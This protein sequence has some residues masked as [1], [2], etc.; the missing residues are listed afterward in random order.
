MI[1]KQGANMSWFKT[2]ITETDTTIKCFNFFGHN[3][4]YYMKKYLASDN[5]TDAIFLK[6]SRISGIEFYKQFDLEVYELF[7]KLTT[8]KNSSYGL[9]K[10]ALKDVVDWFEKEYYP[11]RINHMDEFDFSVIDEKMHF[12]ILPH[13]EEA[14][15]RYREIKTE[16]G[17]RGML[18]F[19]DPGVG[20]SMMGLSLAEVLKSDRVVI[21][22]PKQ[23]IDKVWIYSLTEQVY[24]EPQLYHMVGEG[25]YNKE[26]FVVCSYERLDKL[27]EIVEDVKTP[28][29]TVIVDESHNFADLKSNRTGFLIELV[30]MIDSDNNILMSGTP[31]KS[32]YTELSIIFGLLDKNFKGD[33]SKRF[34]NLY[35]SPSDFLRETLQKRFGL[36]VARVVKDAIKL[37]P[38]QTVYIDVKIKDSN[39]YTLSNIRKE[40]KEYIE[41]RIK[42]Y[43]EN[44][45]RFENIYNT[46]YEKAKARGIADRISPNY[47]KEYE[48]NVQR[49]QSLY[50]S[51][52]LMNYSELMNIVNRFEEDYIIKYLEGNDKKDFR[53]AKTIVKY[54][55]FKVQ[56]EAL[57][58]IVLKNRIAAHRDMAASLNYSDIINSTLK[59]TIV[60]S[61]YV[62]VCDAAKEKI[63]EEKFKPITVYGETTKNLNANVHEFTNKKEINPLVTTFK[64]LSTGVPLIAANVVLVLDLPFRM[65][66]YE[67]AIARVWRLGQDSQVT[68]YILRLDTG[69]EPNINSRNIDIISFFNAEV[70]KITGYSASVSLGNTDRTLSGESFDNDLQDIMLG[71]EDLPTFKSKNTYQILLNW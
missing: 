5:K 46:L 21:I 62:D 32:G 43:K 55:L 61:N 53:E 67:Q 24:K 8:K 35:K 36:Y 41:G 17:Y 38:V 44:Y 59:K 70:E 64:S 52:N 65:Y 19:G 66:I 57:A 49:I 47:Y 39:K 2:K 48:S 27:K 14:F 25:K 23:V 13:Q 30:D 26:K 15:K 45:S 51:G 7:K 11:K 50:K 68:A 54:V 18:L 58:N 40:L 10:G 37:D 33:V 16:N 69:K 6:I 22:C 31:L 34:L 56:G 4:R 20:K 12:K 60:F 9:D 1:L 71:T 3:F 29:T 28:N 42:Y 63:I